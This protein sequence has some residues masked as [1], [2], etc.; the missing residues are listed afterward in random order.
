MYLLCTCA[1]QKYKNYM[2]DFIKRLF[3]LMINNS[4]NIN[5]TGE[6]LSLKL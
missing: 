2:H 1:L 3:K 6:Y 4:S 5:K